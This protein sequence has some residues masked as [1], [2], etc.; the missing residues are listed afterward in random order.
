MYWNGRWDT[1]AWLT[2]CRVLPFSPNNQDDIQPLTSAIFPN[3][4]VSSHVAAAWLRQ[5]S[6]EGRGNK[7]NKGKSLIPNFPNILALHHFDIWTQKEK[8]MTKITQEA[9]RAAAALSCVMKSNGGPAKGHDL[10]FFP[11]AWLCTMDWLG[12]RGGDRPCHFLSFHFSQL[13]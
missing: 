10:F 9:V 11:N 3:N 12:W 1:K 2:I 8:M 4:E 13:G 5:I 6:K 7:K